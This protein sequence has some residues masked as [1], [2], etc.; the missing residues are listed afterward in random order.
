MFI[1]R[2]LECSCTA[3]A[4]MRQIYAKHTYSNKVLQT[5]KSCRL[6]DA[7]KEKASPL[8]LWAQF[9]SSFILYNLYFHK[10]QYSL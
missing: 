8:L 3:M 6:Y 10:I 1:E 7:V 9:V 4:I 2:V 5:V